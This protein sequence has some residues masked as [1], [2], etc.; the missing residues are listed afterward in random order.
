MD[1][2]SVSALILTVTVLVSAAAWA[3]EQSPKELGKALF[4]DPKFAGGQKACNDCHPEGRNLEEAGEKSQFHIMGME[5]K[6][7]EEAINMCITYAIKGKPIP[8]NSREMKAM[9]SYIRSLS[10]KAGPGDDD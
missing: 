10:A 4:N 2:K 8:E 5:Q 6:S 1:S 7:L 9:V 3:L